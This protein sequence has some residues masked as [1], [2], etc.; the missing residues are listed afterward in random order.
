MPR[1]LIA[2]LFTLAILHAQP[3]KA[4]DLYNEIM[5]HVIT[6]CIAH[7]TQVTGLD[8]ELGPREAHDLILRMNMPIYERVMSRVARL[9][10]KSSP[11]VRGAIYRHSL[12]ACIDATV[13]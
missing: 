7:A 8:Q 9:V 1:T 3:A 10:M 4:E 12:H 13:R 2:A 6:P 11:R 5:S